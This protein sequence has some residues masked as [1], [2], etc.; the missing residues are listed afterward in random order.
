MELNAWTKI[1]VPIKAA[2]GLTP[3]LVVG[4]QASSRA[5]EETTSSYATAFCKHSY[6]YRKIY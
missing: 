3:R 5:Y 6:V 1:V 2:M 4:R